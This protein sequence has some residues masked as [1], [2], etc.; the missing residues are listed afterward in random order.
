MDGN[1]FQLEELVGATQ[2]SGNR[3]REFLRIPAMSC[4]MYLLPAGGTDD[5]TPHIEDEIYVVVKGEA[6]VQIADQHSRVGPGSVIFVP[7]DLEHRF[8]DITS[9]LEL[10][11]VFAPAYTGRRS[12][13]PAQ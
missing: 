2:S 11:V 6:Q 12:A 13:A 5:Q 8:H 1:V 3:F 10:L 9:D 4:G 7:A